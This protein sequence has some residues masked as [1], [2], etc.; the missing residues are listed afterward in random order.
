[1]A[2]YRL[3]C[4]IPLATATSLLYLAIAA[5]STPPKQSQ[6]AAPKYR[7]ID[8]GAVQP[9]AASRATA[10]NNHGE[11][12][13][14][15]HTDYEHHRSYL[16]K[17]GK[18]I[19]LGSLGGGDTNATAI[20]DL[21]EVIGTSNTAFKH[22]DNTPIFHAFVWRNGQIADLGT[23]GGAASTDQ[24]EHADADTRDLGYSD[25]SCPYAINNSGEVVGFGVFSPND[26]KTHGVIWQSGKATDIGPY[27][28][29]AI[30]DNGRIACQ[31]IVAE[32]P[33]QAY[34]RT[35]SNL[36]RLTVFGSS[37]CYNNHKGDI[38]G[39]LE[40]GAKT[41]SQSGVGVLTSG[42]KLKATYKK[43]QQVSCI[44][45][46]DDLCGDAGNSL[47]NSS[48]CV[49]LNGKVYAAADLL[50][51]SSGWKIESFEALNDKEEIVGQGTFHGH[52]RAFLMLPK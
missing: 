25:S 6:T 7:I 43:L 52:D 22:T 28:G 10:I 34:L 1:M 11:V 45:D 46:S 42:G 13:I 14:S 35:G 3:A 17:A 29:D 8:L 26:N 50:P 48:P 27:M 18:A 19:D 30:D 5:Q 37:A 44:N 24:A 9:N 15:V 20:N 47:A 2:D 4:C 36:M 23:P 51:P 33:E 49:V 12:V 21:G 38:A 16:W 40:P 31:Q 32:L 39:C 41:I